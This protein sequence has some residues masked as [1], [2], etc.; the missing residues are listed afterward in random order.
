M[1]VVE[2]N[3]T[4][5]IAEKKQVSK[6]KIRISNN[7]AIEKV[8]KSTFSIGQDTQDTL[9][10]TFKFVSKFEPDVGAIELIGNLV[11]IEA[12]EQVQEIEEMWKKGKKLPKEVMTEVLNVV[13]AR[14]NTQA[15]ILSRDI[16][17]PSP[18]PLPKVK[19]KN[20]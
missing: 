7:V 20:A 15:L 9:K 12:K 18:I 17:L 8:E 10:F 6:G 13:L 2:F 19:I 16:N 3:F 4:N 1:T 14:C 11:V 5:I